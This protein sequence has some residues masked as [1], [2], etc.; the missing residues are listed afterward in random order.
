MDAF[1][2]TTLTNPEVLAVDQY[3]AYGHP[4]IEKDNAIVW[5]AEAAEH[6][7]DYFAIFNLADTP[8]TLTYTW[9]ELGIGYGKCPVRDLWKRDE[10][11]S[12]N[13]ITVTLPPHG[14]GLYQA[15]HR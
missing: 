1:T 9:E 11:G 6:H 7:G 14:A 15:E 12:M 4:I 10:I 8:Q 5:M 2:E 3:S 13:E